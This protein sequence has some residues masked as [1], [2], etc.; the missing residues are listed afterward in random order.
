MCQVA[1]L[2]RSFPRGAARSRGT[3]HLKGWCNPAL[4]WGGV[5]RGGLSWAVLLSRVSAKVR[6]HVDDV[7]LS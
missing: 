1:G 2:E 7:F 3:A 5:D 4:R 6:D